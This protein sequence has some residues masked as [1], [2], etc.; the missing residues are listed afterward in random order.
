M[1]YYYG[2]RYINNNALFRR[3]LEDENSP[4]L[5]LNR[6]WNEL[7]AGKMIVVMDTETTGL[8]A[9]DADVIEIS[10]VKVRLAPAG[11][12]TPFVVLDTFDSYINPG[13]ELPAVIVEFNRKNGTGICDEFLADKPNSATVAHE[14][15]SF[16]KKE[17]AVTEDCILVG[18]N[19]ETFDVPFIEKLMNAGG[20]SIPFQKTFDTYRYAK[21]IIPFAGKGTHTLGSLH[22][23]TEGIF[24]SS[25]SEGVAHT[26]IFD[27]LMTL[28][29]VQH[30]TSELEKARP[31]PTEPDVQKKPVLKRIEHER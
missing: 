9:K 29:L 1:G 31:I 17:P 30:F 28:D 2:G 7:L 16:F 18:H 10:A 11:S 14:L 12:K 4:K 3:E 6:F 27:C 23:K 21:E 5:S 13:Y 8:S 22:E 24:S 20:H 26:S 19:Q 25:A 15:D